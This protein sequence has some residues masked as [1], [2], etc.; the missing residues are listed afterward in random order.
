MAEQQARAKEREARFAREAAKPPP[1]LPTHRMTVATGK[2]AKP[3]KELDVMVAFIRRKL[4]AGL[5]LSPDV[6]AKAASLQIDIDQILPSNGHVVTQHHGQSGKRKRSACSGLDD[7]LDQYWRQHDVR[8]NRAVGPDATAMHAGQHPIAQGRPSTSAIMA[9]ATAP[10]AS[11]AHAVD[12]RRPARR[13]RLSWLLLARK[14]SIA[15][16]TCRAFA[17]RKSMSAQHSA[18]ATLAGTRRRRTPR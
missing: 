6:R 9:S 13:W 3:T 1:P 4:S 16:C 17:F 8:S 11:T 14:A 2:V 5:P 7:D 12:F 18:A 15:T 10:A